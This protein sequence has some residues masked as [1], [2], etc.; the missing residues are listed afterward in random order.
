MKPR[1]HDH[2]S[3]AIAPLPVPIVALHGRRDAQ[4]SHADM[5]A[6]QRLTTEAFTLREFSGDHSFINPEQNE[7]E[8]IEYVLSMLSVS[9]P[10]SRPRTS[11]YSVP[12]ADWR[13]S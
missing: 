13:A 7:A 5:Q 10:E 1:C 11:R 3:T 8:V 2:A 6:W 9:G 12:A 4:V